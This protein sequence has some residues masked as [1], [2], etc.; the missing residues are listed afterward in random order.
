MVMKI[1]EVTSKSIIT[2]SKLPDADY[3]VNPYIGCSFACCYCYA[4]FMGRVVGE[5]IEAWGRYVYIK[6]NAV[7]LFDKELAKFSSKARQGS[8][9]LSS[10]TD[11]WQGPEKKYRLA[12]GI[13]NIL[14]RERYPGRV[15]LLTKSP[16]IIEDI[17]IIGRLLAPDVGV[18]L[19]STDEVISHIFE[20]QAPLPS[21]RLDILKRFNQ[22][23]IP[24]YAFV[25][26]LLPHF[27]FLP[28]KLEQLFSQIAATGTT[29]IYVEQINLS[30]YIRKRL[31]SVMRDAAP[32]LATAYAQADEAE[33]RRV[34][35]EMVQE[36]A[37]RFGLE[38]RLAT[39]L[40][41]GQN[42]RQSG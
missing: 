16:L 17:E 5:P 30:A 18:T 31:D 24:T 22:A 26:P 8:L 11:A 42:A 13:L 38:I 40:T 7:E 20:A 10:V 39:V 19:T 21:T 14:A 25:G 4:S 29:Q 2:K 3:V 6:T 15:S 27:R 41:H 12:H 32:D 35:G 34:V 36:I 23:G 28:H 9:L 37:P 33:H 1:A